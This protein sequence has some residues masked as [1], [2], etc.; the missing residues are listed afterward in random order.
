MTFATLA[1]VVA[2]LGWV[3]IVVILT[4]RL[5]RTEQMIKMIMRD[6]VA[7]E[8]ALRSE[9]HQLWEERQQM[10]NALCEVGVSVKANALD[11]CR[12]GDMASDTHSEVTA[13]ARTLDHHTDRLS[14]LE[15]EQ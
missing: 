5:D 2:L 15:R 3:P 7:A 12:I 13:H 1:F 9:I 4:V 11:I 10:I 8:D 14:V 6:T